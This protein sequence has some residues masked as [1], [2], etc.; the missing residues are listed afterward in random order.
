MAPL[1]CTVREVNQAMY[2]PVKIGNQERH[3]LIDTGSTVTI[4]S[5]TALTQSHQT[6]LPEIY[7]TE[8]RLLQ[9][10]GTP[11]KTSGETKLTMKCG[12]QKH[13]VPVVIADIEVDGILGMDFLQNT[14]STIDCEHK[15][16]QIQGEYIPCIDHHD[17]E[18]VMAVNQ[19]EVPE[20]LEDIHARTKHSIDDEYHSNVAK[21]LNDYSDVFSKGDH[22]IGSTDKIHHSIHTTC[23]APIRQRPRRHPMGQREEVEKQIQD[24]LDRGIIKHSTSPWSSPI[25]LVDKKDGTKR[26]CIDY[27]LLNKHT[28]KDSF[29][30]P[31]I[32]ESLDALDGAKYFCT[33][34]LASGYWQV[35]LD[36][37]AKLKSAFVVPGGLYQFEV[38]P[39]GL[40]NAPSTFERLMENILTGLQWKILLIYLDDVIVFGSTVQE[41]IDRLKIILDRLREANLKLKPKKCHLFQTEV[42][43]LGHV[44]TSEGVK[45]DPSKVEAVKSWPTPTNPTEVRSFLGLASYYRRFIYKFSEV[46][47]PLTNLTKKDQP[48]IWSSE[49]E[50][51][52]NTMKELLTT[53]PILAYPRIDAEFILDTDASK[54]A[55]GAVLSQVHEGKERVIAYASRTLGRAEQNYCVT[56]SELL[57]VVVFLKHFRHY[58]Y[59]QRVRVRT[60]HGALR[61]LLNF[62]NPEGQ[63]ARWLEVITQYQLTLEH[64][65]GRIHSNADGMS[66]RPCRQCNRLE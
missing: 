53:T 14:N 48:F 39:F 32:A 55:I 65:A 25:V 45:T 44:V 61:W 9:A 21:L 15:F 4:V 46:V 11:I 28:V 62:K 12:T 34:D 3:F 64:R 35:P 41:V 63:L 58:L 52:F 16:I 5:R 38:M 36:D 26:F 29:P 10:N 7:E 51:A 37:D 24:M 56:R 54:F 59:G 1:I 17:N 57:A 13:D 43:Y 60:D 31:S 30:L 6:Q 27:R 22:D 50:K 40:C 20:H 42:L 49:C 2:I 18:Q 19:D 23:A 47:K 33:L 66:R 8:V